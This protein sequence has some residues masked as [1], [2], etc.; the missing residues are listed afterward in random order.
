MTYLQFL[1]VFVVPPLAAVWLLTLRVRRAPGADPALWRT[2][3]VVLAVL[4]AVAWVWTTPWD[5]WLIGQGTWSY[6]PGRVIVRFFGIPAEEYLFMA[7]QTL[8]IGLWSLLLLAR[9]TPSAPGGA[10]HR[11]LPAAGW[12]AAACVGAVLALSSPHG[13]YLGSM[14]VWFGPLLAVQS[15]VGG[16]LLR[17]R[18]SARLGVLVPALVWLWVSDRIALS[19]DIWHISEELTYGVPLLGLP[20]EEAVFFVIT[21]LLVAN[22]LTLA[23]DPAAQERLRSLRRREGSPV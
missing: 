3:T 6:A 15:A 21:C 18:R 10:R 9:A 13:T 2:G 14:L 20:L 1:G 22:G 5:S 16:D 19:L 8:L 23:V 11:I 12:T 7:L 4:C 17:A